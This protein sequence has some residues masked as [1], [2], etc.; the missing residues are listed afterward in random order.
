MWL[1]T[2]MNKVF[3]LNLRFVWNLKRTMNMHTSNLYFLWAFCIF[4][5][6]KL[7][8]YH[9][10]ILTACN[11]AYQKTNKRRHKLVIMKLKY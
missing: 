8:N 2:V 11:T 5:Q 4:C 3:I 10:K 7:I 9:L 6:I 1:N